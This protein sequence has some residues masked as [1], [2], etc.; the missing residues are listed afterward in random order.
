MPTEKDI[1]AADLTKRID[2]DLSNLPTGVAE[3]DQKCAELVQFA[4]AN[5]WD[6]DTLVQWVMVTWLNETYKV[7]T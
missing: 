1:G 2:P 4:M 6:R 7:R 3:M 5:K